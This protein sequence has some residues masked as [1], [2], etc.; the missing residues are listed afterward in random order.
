[1]QETYSSGDYVAAELGYYFA[2]TIDWDNM[3][4][5]ANISVLSRFPIQDVFVPPKSTFMSV[6]T[7]VSLSQS[8]DIYVMS[9][10]FGMR[11]FEDVFEFHRARFDESDSIPTLFAG[12]FNAV[13]HTDGG[14]SPASKKLLEYQFTDAYRELYPDVKKYPGYTHRSN[15]RIDQLYYKGEGLKNISTEVFSAWPSKFPSDHYLLKSE[16]ELDYSTKEQ[17][18]P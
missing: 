12:D 13:P 15:R 14:Q 8:Q 9:S 7:K 18:G 1:M 6:G 10:W 16:F 11:N 2:T 3:H 5:G 4:Q 17:M